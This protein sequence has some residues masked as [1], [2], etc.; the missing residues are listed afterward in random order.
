[1]KE[2]IKRDSLD[3]GGFSISQHMTSAAEAMLEIVY[4]WLIVEKKKLRYCI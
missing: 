2:A 4:D 1:L 3:A